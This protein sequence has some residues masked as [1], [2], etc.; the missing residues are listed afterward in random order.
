MKSKVINLFGDKAS[1]NKKGGVKYS[2]LLEQF[3]KRFED[4]FNDIEFYEDVVDFAVTAWNFGNMKLILPQG[5]SDAI[6]DAIK[7][8]DVDVDLLKRMIAFKIEKF[9]DYSDFIVDYE[10]GERKGDPLLTVVTQEQDAYL[11]AMAEDM[12]DGHSDDDFE[13]NY[14]N[15]TALILKPLQPFSDWLMNLYPGEKHDLTE[16]TTYLIS[17]EIE[18][19]EAFLKKKFD[20]L[21]IRELEGWHTNKKDWPQKRTYKMFKQWFQV[22]VSTMV[23]DLENEPV[24]K[25]G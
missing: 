14:I 6:V 3:L 18:D 21:F 10:V 25:G 22:E 19:E 16:M 13:E 11:D 9:K 1:D 5:E 20:D 24:F 7:D 17:L 15:R 12:E 4:D 2:E 23:Y 8:K